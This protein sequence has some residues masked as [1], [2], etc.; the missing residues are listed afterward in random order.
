MQKVAV[1]MLLPMLFG[2][3]ADGGIVIGKVNNDKSQQVDGG[4]DSY[5]RSNRRELIDDE[6]SA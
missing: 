2:K 5:N 6:E 4:G 3:S 1:L